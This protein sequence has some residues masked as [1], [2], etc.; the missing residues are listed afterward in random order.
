MEDQNDPPSSKRRKSALLDTPG[1]LT[2]P[3][4]NRGVLE[5]LINKLTKLVER[6]PLF[7]SKLEGMLEIP[8]IN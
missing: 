1:S 3:P 4:Q 7:H 6:H 2:P 5:D 8:S